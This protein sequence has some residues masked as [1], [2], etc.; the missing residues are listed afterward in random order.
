MFAAM[1][2]F[3]RKIGVT[4]PVRM[5]VTQM[6]MRGMRRPRTWRVT[7]VRAAIRAAGDLEEAEVDKEIASGAP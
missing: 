2:R 4:P 3:M 7:G 1:N 6:R 5:M